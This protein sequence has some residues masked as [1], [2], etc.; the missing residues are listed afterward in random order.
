MRAKREKIDAKESLR[1]IRNTILFGGEE[2]RKVA[3]K[4]VYALGKEGIYEK[5]TVSYLIDLYREE[6]GTTAVNE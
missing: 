2:L 3:A 1:I 6:S 5:E 4:L